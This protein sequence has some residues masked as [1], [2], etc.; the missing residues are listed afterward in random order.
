MATTKNEEVI[1]TTKAPIGIYE[2]LMVMR[3]EYLKRIPD[4]KKTGLNKYSNYTYYELGDFLPICTEIA[5]KYKTVIIYSIDEKDATLTVINTE[6]T[7][8]RLYFSMPLAEANVKGANAIQNLGSLKTYTKRYLYFD[9]FEIA[10][11]DEFE[12]ETGSPA[13]KKESAD[14]EQKKADEEAEKIKAEKITPNKVA[15]IKST[16]L[17]A[18]ISE[19][20]VC[21]RYSIDKLEDLTEGNFPKLMNDIEKTLEKMKNAGASQ[22]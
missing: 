11:S 7:E 22:N 19:E 20:A 4:I 2:K 17:E 10:E 15:A 6:N 16:L 5:C 9:V 21:K 1:E 13:V 18:G 12:P 8:E 3:Q 14:A